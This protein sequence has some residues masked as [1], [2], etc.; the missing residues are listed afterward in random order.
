MARQGKNWRD[1][2]VASVETLIRD[3]EIPDELVVQLTTEL[4]NKGAG[5]ETKDRATKAKKERLLNKYNSMTPAQQR[6]WK[7]NNPNTAKFIGV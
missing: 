6:N 1:E 5:A 7:R 3:P 2:D 4:A